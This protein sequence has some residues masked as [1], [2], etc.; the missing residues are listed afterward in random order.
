MVLL[1]IWNRFTFLWNHGNWCIQNIS[2][3]QPFYYTNKIV[4]INQCS[5]CI[6]FSTLHWLC[7][8]SNFQMAVDHPVCFG[9]HFFVC[10]LLIFIFLKDRRL[11]YEKIVHFNI[12]MKFLEH[13][14]LNMIIEKVFL[15]YFHHL[16]SFSC[17]INWLHYPNTEFWNDL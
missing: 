5:T 16:C 11:E 15:R 4:Q 12:L 13:P 6:L 17:I 7:K 3:S 9:V 10:V 2:C 1:A 14:I 8:M